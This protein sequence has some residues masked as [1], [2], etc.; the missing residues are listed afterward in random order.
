MKKILSFLLIGLSLV[1]VSCDWLGG[2]GDPTIPIPSPEIVQANVEPALVEYNGSVTI[3]W[4]AK[5]T[6]KVFVD[7]IESSS[8]LILKNQTVSKNIKIIAYGSEGTSPDTKNISF[9]VSPEYVPNAE[10]TLMKSYW[11]EISHEISSDNISFKNLS[12]EEKDKYHQY[13]FLQ[14]HKLEIYKT[15]YNSND[16]IGGGELYIW[17]V[18]GRILSLLDEKFSFTLKN[19]SLILF[20]KGESEDI[21]TGEKR[22]LWHRLT[23]NAINK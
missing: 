17:K 2:G 23:Y 22:P 20:K 18:E 13:R 19:N 12:F 5:N 3:S 9:T 14:N 6:K 1:I 7:G 4:Q 11:I 15:P 21:Q 8:P 10:D 16:L